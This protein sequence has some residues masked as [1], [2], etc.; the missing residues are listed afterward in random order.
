MQIDGSVAFVTGA[1]RGL[2][3][4]FVQA[5]LARGAAKVYAGV[6]TPSAV[7]EL[8]VIPIELDITDREQ[9]EAAA[10]FASDADIVVNSAG[11]ATPGRPLTVSLADARRD[12]EVNVLGTLS[13]AQV[14]APVLAANGGGALVTMLSVMSW[15]T[16]PPISVYAASKAASWSL[17]NALRIQLRDQNTLVTAVYCDSVA[18]DMTA[19]LAKPMLSP[20]EVV[21]PVLAAVEAGA[22]EV[23]VGEYT[24]TVR[25]SLPDELQLLYPDGHR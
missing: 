3:R 8:D 6:R 15:V 7:S 23:L 1:N 2:G 25:A 4:A 17:T 20:A 19:G 5:L 9:V 22:E 16:A 12:L 14:F 18:T 21:C 13:V 24:R 10:A 11:I